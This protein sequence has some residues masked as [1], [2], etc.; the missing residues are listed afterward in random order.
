[1]KN[2]RTSNLLLLFT[3]YSDQITK[4]GK[5]FSSGTYTIENQ[6]YQ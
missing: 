1:M 6:F 5:A 3:T 4:Q 2:E